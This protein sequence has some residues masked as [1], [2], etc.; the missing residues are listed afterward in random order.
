MRNVCLFVC[1]YEKHSQNVPLDNFNL[2]RKVFKGAGKEEEKE[3]KSYFLHYLVAALTYT[4][5]TNSVFTL[6]A[7][8][9]A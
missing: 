8:K 4:N 5:A 6:N 9:H 1:W 7:F 3:R 2:T